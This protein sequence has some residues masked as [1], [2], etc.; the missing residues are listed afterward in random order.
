MKIVLDTQEIES[1]DQFGEL[2]RDYCFVS[3]QYGGMTGC[4]ST[5]SLRPEFKEVPATSIDYK[6]MARLIQNEAIA[7]FSNG[8]I[9]IAWYW[10]GDGTLV[11]KE[12]KRVAINTDCKKD[13]TWE[14][15]E[16]GKD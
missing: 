13:Y 14:W 16:Y 3:D 8:T 15:V 1:S 11:F 12:G 2:L 6:Y 10:D 4:Y 7:C 9:L 5:F